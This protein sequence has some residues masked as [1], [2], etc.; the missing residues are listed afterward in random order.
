MQGFKKSI[1]IQPI[2]DAPHKFSSQEK[3]CGAVSDPGAQTTT[4]SSLMSKIILQ[5]YEHLTKTCKN[6]ITYGFGENKQ[7]YLRPLLN[8][9]PTIQSMILMEKVDLFLANVL[10]LIQLYL[11]H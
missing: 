10:V 2:L 1:G 7:A 9:I 11:L 6:L 8:K 5:L 3:W 4:I